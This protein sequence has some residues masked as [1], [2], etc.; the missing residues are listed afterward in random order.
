MPADRASASRAIARLW[1]LPLLVGL[2]VG[3][4]LTELV[5]FPLLSSRRRR[6]AIRLWSRALLGACGLSLEADARLA[7]L[8][9]GRM[10]VANHVSW[11][12]IFAIDAVAPA[13]FVA[14][15]EIRRWPVLG[16]LVA[17]AGTVFIE[18]ARRH[19]VHEAILQLRERIRTGYP[20]AVFPEATTSDGRRLLPFYGNLLEAARQEN[21]EVL[22]VGLRYRD[23]AGMPSAETEY[24]GEQTFIGSLWRITGASG[25]RVE[26]SL[27]ETL[28]VGGRTRQELASAARLAL[29]RRLGLPLE[30]TPAGTL[31]RLPA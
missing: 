18:R 8:A 3:G 22:V 26:V 21:A 12:D 17:F 11:L 19:A 9:P 27:V 6:T 31:R 5:V 20:V 10:I 28:A 7:G 13:A 30:D 25:L 1:R 16:L 2:L 15:A 29:S 4:I 24:I 14:K 23:A